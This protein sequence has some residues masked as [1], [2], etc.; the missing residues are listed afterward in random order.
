MEKRLKIC[1]PCSLQGLVVIL[2]VCVHT[3]NIII[4]FFTSLVCF[5]SIGFV[6]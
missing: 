1:M 3:K 2:G 5:S 6:E 4:T